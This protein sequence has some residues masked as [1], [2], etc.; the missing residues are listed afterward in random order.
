[1]PSSIG[2]FQIIFLPKFHCELNPIEQGWGY[3]KRVYRF[4]PEYDQLQNNAIESLESV[5]IDGNAFS[6]D[7][8]LI[9]YHSDFL[10][11]LI[12]FKLSTRIHAVSMEG[13]QPGI[14]VNIAVLHSALYKLKLYS[15]Y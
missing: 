9:S 8:L 10:I 11:M 1:L 12:D 2:G 3:A 5:P 7:P 13:S 14:Q 4:F 6:P 15:E